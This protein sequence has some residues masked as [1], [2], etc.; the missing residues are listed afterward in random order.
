MR[1]AQASPDEISFVEMHGTGTQIG[2][3]AEMG[4]VANTFKHRRRAN[5]P[6]T[7]GGVKANVGHGEAAAGIAELLKVIMM[8]KK[9]ILPPQAGMPHA[10]NPK[11]P[12]LSDLNIEILS[13]PKEFKKHANRPRKVLLNNFDAAGG[14]ACMLLEDFTPARS[15][16]QR[17]A[18]PR[19]NHVV[20]SS[21]RTKA[22]YHANKAKL[23]KW[24]KENPSTRLEDV[25]YT[26]TARRMQ[27]PFRFATTASSIQDLVSKLEA[28]DAT[29]SPSP[30]SQP[31]I[32]FVYT[33]Q[34]SHY[35]GM[36]AELYRTSPVFRETVDLAVAI[37]GSH[38]FPP[39]LDIITNDQVD[40]STK[41]AAQIQ[42]AVVTLEIALTAF[43]RSAGIEPALVLGHSLGEYAALYA[44]GVLS[45]ADTLY[46]VGQRA[47]LLLERCEP[48]SCAMLSVST[49]VS[50]VRDQLSSVLSSSCGVACIN[51]PSATVVSGTAE[52]L[53]QFQSGITARDA[54]VRSTKLS[55]PFAFHSFQVDP[56]LEDYISLAAGVTYSAPKIPVAS[57]L[58]AT[59]VDGPGVFNQDYLA[60]QT[61]QAVDFVGALNAIHSKLKDPVWIEV[62]PAPVCASF[63]RATLSPAPSRVLYSIE[64]R[65]SN[66]SSISKTLSAAY[67][68]GIDVDWLALHRPYESNLA[69]LNLPTYAWDMKDYWVTW[70]ER[71]NEVVPAK[72]QIAAPAP[73]PYIATCAQYLVEQSLSPN[74]KVTLRAVI[75]DPGFLALID[76]HKMQQV[77]LASGSVFCDAA[78]TT[79]KYALEYSGRKNITASNLTLHDPELLSPLTRSL[80][81]LDGQL[82]TTATLESPSSN[83]ILVTYKAIS[84][85]GEP[86]NLGSMRVQVADPEKT[87]VEWDRISYFIK[88][89]LE[90]RIKKSRDGSGHRMLPD[91]I[92]ALFAKAVE[93]DPS[94]KGIQEGYIANDF[95]E[96]AAE[97][98]LKP[99]PA[100]NKF[101]FSPY[102]SE[103]LAHLAGFMVN[104]NPNRS[105]LKTFIV[106]GFESVQQTIDFEPGKKYFTYTRISRWEK[107][108]AFCDAFVFDPE[109]SN[110]VM[111]CLGLR[112]Q[113]LPKATWKHILEGHHG[114]AKAAPA[115]R[116]TKAPVSQS[117]TAEAPKEKHQSTVETAT[118]GQ[119]QEEESADAGVFDAILASITKSTGTDPSEFQDD[120]LLSELGVDS[121]MAIEIVATVSAESGFE[122]PASF[123]FDYP[124]IG[125]LRVE[126]GAKSK[127][128]SPSST[129]EP[130]AISAPSSPEPSA[131][132]SPIVV[133][134]SISSLSSS[135]VNIA[136][137]DSEPLDKQITPTKVDT[138]P[139]PT[140][141]ITLLKGRPGPGKT[142][143]YLM[144]D[145][146][147]SI[148]T[149]IHLPP[150]KS[151]L[152]VYGID[153]PFLRC[154]SRLTPEIGI[155]GVAALIVAALLKAQPTGSLYI[156]G[157]SAGSMIAYEVSRQL[158]IAGRTV[159]GLVLIDL[160]APRH[161]YLT[162]AQIVEESKIGVAVF[163]AAVAT[164]GL[165]SPTP[166]TEDH[167]RAYFVAMRQYDAPIMGPDH[168]PVKSAVIWAEKGLVNRIAHDDKA[169]QFL[170]DEGIP[171]VAYPGFMEDPRLS[172]MACLVPDKTEKDLGDNGWARYTGEILT[173]SV[174]ADHLDLPMPGH[175]H[176]LHEQLERA[177][178]YFAKA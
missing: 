31:P 33:G 107:D 144:A 145:G 172:P 7:V 141:R 147:G 21:A 122:L 85:K 109:T 110:L 129:V 10:L 75:G 20:V 157:F 112:Y 44:A 142:P 40:V 53:A 87:Q 132:S 165:W 99:D 38:D 118:V 163:G 34:G 86:H 70:V 151:N 23:V 51:S 5:G 126:F 65:S 121:I 95:E 26:T 104:G 167:L 77:G 24:L 111:Q 57:T 72:A 6:L 61:R 18:D 170:K 45:L 37:S 178:A 106:M 176:L 117:K 101:T 82:F 138:S 150:F 67:T 160:A 98:I 173:L 29:S 115:S 102:W 73:E 146:T 17:A 96:A 158:A 60:H 63:V 66:W 156:G 88:A 11:F 139:L 91:I 116:A 15:D 148:A 83:T 164:D 123:V 124:T 69:L 97:V 114:G 153:S 62:G 39:F 149:Y 155:P 133:P 27:H 166:L 13:E 49:S 76:G 143:F 16:Q 79:A 113:E 161:T 19:T 30:S 162:L 159:A 171:A 41:D 32:V 36:G 56:I 135:V 103:A 108:T 174:D 89:K 105:P 128:S 81:G 71:G 168:R 50:A 154:P 94:F 3:P 136:T 93:F 119:Q 46:L 100:G 131:H 92:Y 64:S 2:D 58:L 127:V 78:L 43:W 8:F 80:V 130:K 52:D 84:A 134:E 137:P 175:V 4:A 140:V 1:N 120:T 54:K 68:N 152:P 55:V 42:L 90:E 25:A 14:N 125:A 177:F 47:R 9:D 59:V 22:A 169:M 74:V 35:A 48:G 12:P 28:P